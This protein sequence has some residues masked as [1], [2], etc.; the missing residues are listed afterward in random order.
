MPDG[1]VGHALD[2]HRDGIERGHALV[3]RDRRRE[4]LEVRDGAVERRHTVG[5]EGR[6]AEPLVLR[7]ARASRGLHR[8]LV[9]LERAAGRSPEDLAAVHDRRRLC[10]P[11]RHDRG[12]LVGPDVRHHLVQDHLVGERDGGEADRRAPE[13][14]REP[15]EEAPQVEPG[16]VGARDAHRQILS[17][18]LM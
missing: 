2:R 10:A 9:A 11:A 7:P 5:V 3:R 4:D 1:E 18:H 15:N 6:R 8:A 12:A 14:R 16:S 17:F 13:P